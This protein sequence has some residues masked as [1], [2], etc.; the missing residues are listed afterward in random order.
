M[1]VLVLNCGS[2]S[3][4]FQ[5]IDTDLEAIERDADRRL[6]QGRIERVGGHALITAQA[7]G[8][9]KVV[10]DAPL[11][12]HR[13][14]VDWVLRWVVSSEAGI[15]SITSVSDIHAVG[16]RVVHGGERFQSSVRIDA[17][18]LAGI[19]ECIEL[20]PLHNPANLKGIRAARAIL[21]EGLP[22]VAVFDTAFHATLPEVSYLYG[23][24][25]H[26]CPTVALHEIAH[27]VKDGNLTDSWIT[28]SRR[29]KLTI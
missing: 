4:R 12:D 20:A 15:E 19:E 24:P 21:G 13:A 3:V 7:T 27:V 8:R 26:I 2:S 6:A 1:N 11:R 14:A 18:V 5:I 25:Y 22:D 29:R 9:A 17:E 16:H 10:E 28:Q 23:I